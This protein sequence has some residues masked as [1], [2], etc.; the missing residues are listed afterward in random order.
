MTTTENSNGPG[1]QEFERDLDSVSA[2]YRG[3]DEEQPPELVDLAVL[4]KARAAVEKP[5]VWFWNMSWVH[6]LTTVA[7]LAVAAVIVFQ[8]SDE[9][10]IPGDLAA[11]APAVESSKA[12]ETMLLEEAVQ[13]P[14]AEPESLDESERKDDLATEQRQVARERA[15][16]AAEMHRM[17]AAKTSLNADREV[18]ERPNNMAS[19]V[20]SPAATVAD[21]ADTAADPDAT[22]GMG[23]AEI[24]LDRI[25]TLRDS[26]ETDA[27]Q[28]GLAAFRE[29]FPGYP[30]PEDL[31]D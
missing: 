28:E 15:E 17:E 25:R 2:A 1:D 16:P 30:I 8:V 9:E 14:A 18:D 6:G 21:Q 11:P 27:A 3:L 13:L 23:E 10:A 12:V 20:A 19:L 31:R 29:M 7:V 4:N 24:W 5:R 22:A 26:G